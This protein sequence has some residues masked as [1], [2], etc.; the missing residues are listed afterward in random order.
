M[1][2]FAK[3]GRE[4]FYP[5]AVYLWGSPGRGVEH[6]PPLSLASLV[7]RYSSIT[8]RLSRP[9][10]GLLPPPQGGGQCLAIAPDTVSGAETGS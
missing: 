8:P 7:E 9:L 3:D 5:L 10:R 4:V 1:S 6:P 2:L